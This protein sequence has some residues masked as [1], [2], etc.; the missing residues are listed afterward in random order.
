MMM[1]SSF[2]QLPQSSKVLHLVSL[3]LVGASTV[4]LMAPAAFHR[5]VERGEDTERFHTFASAM[6]LAA[7]AALGPA[8]SIELAIV[9]RKLTGTV[10][11][12]AAAGAGALACFYGAWFG[13]TLV[14]RARDRRSA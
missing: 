13:L 6:V 12:A 8:F 5:I 11:P 1:M 4:L 2:E 9:T 14:L 3:C 10:A 7:M